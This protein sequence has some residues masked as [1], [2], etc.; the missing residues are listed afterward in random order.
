MNLAE[1]LLF[2]AAATIDMTGELPPGHLDAL[3]AVGLYGAQGPAE[4]GGLDDTEFQRTV[5]E[6]AGGCLATTFVWIQHH[7]AVRAVAAGSPELRDRWLTGLCSGLCRAAVAQAG[8]RPGGAALRARPVDGGYVLDG[9]APWVTGWGFVDV[10]HTAARQDDDTLIW[11]LVDAK[12]GAGLSVGALDLVAVNA[13]R[14]VL[15]RFDGHF[16]PADR[17]TSTMSLAEW[18]A[19]DAARL[20]TNGS[21]ALGAVSRS[22]RL[23]EPLDAELTAALRDELNARRDQLDRAGP[24]LMPAARA[25]ASELAL[26]AASTLAVA[27]GAR[28][29]LVGQHAQ[30]LIR[31]A[32]FLLVFGSRPAIRN[33]LTRLVAQAPQ[34]TGYARS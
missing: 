28:G 6:L 12:T 25:A 24:A 23:L 9:E 19:H 20:R 16:V 27:A 4:L 7:G 34:P 11:L 31:E 21:L 8:A 15:A 10:V 18:P 33:E 22:I 13:S 30:R 14:T 1:D 17:V 29:I 32:A 2:P 3:A 5:E 26:R